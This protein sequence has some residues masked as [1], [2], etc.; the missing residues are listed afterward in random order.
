VIYQR[1]GEPEQAEQNY[2]A[3]LNIDSD[4]TPVRANLA[5]FCSACARLPDVERVLAGGVKRARQQGDLQYSLGLVLAEQGKLAQAADALAAVARLLPARAP[6]TA[7][8]ASRC[9][10][11]A[12]RARLAA[13]CARPHAWVRTTRQR[14]MYW[15]RLVVVAAAPHHADSTFSGPFT[16]GVGSHAPEPRSRGFQAPR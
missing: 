3:A 12:S 9:S 2:L 1:S 10:R 6:S 4:F 7:T 11:P 14:P 5:Q 15:L 13:R 8:S 16:R